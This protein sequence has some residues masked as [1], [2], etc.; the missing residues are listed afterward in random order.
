MQAVVEVK[1]VYKSYGNTQVIRRCSFNIREGEIYGLLGGNGAGKT[2]LMKMILGLQRTD[3]GSI[4]VP[5]REAGGGRAWLAGV[6][7]VIET[8]VFYEHLDAGFFPC[9]W[10]TWKRKRISPEEGGKDFVVPVLSASLP[11]GVLSAEI[12]M[13]AAGI[14]W[15]KRS[16]TVTIVSAVILV[17]FVPNLIASRPESMVWAMLLAAVPLGLAAVLTHRILVNGIEEME[18]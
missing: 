10:H 8:P 2:T 16:V 13:I 7:S 6:G 11:A 14:G 4:S 5:G 9:I 15:K 3:E 1:G 18:V 17:C 12:G